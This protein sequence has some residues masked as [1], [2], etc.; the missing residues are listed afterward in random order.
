MVRHFLDSEDRVFAPSRV[1][2]DIVIELRWYLGLK[3][4][5]PLLTDYRLRDSLGSH[6]T[7]GLIATRWLDRRQDL[8]RIQLHD[9]APV[10]L[11]RLQLLLCL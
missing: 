4:G 11:V 5:L 1:C 8:I 9:Y 10:L 2:G 7:M 6:L 3:R